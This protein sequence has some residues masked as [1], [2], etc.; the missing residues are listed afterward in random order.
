MGFTFRQD[1]IKCFAFRATFLNCLK[2]PHMT[3]HKLYSNIPPGG[4]KKMDIWV[5]LFLYMY[6]PDTM[7]LFRPIQMR[8]SRQESNLYYMTIRKCVTKPLDS[9]ST[10]IKSYSIQIKLN[11]RSGGSMEMMGCRIFYWW[12]PLNT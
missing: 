4:A 9:F 6:Y 1:A 10:E 7:C 3:R 11:S 2:K 5:H 12:D 8:L